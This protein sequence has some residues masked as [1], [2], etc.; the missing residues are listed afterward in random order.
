[1]ADGGLIAS[2][3]ASR[4]TA[5]ETNYKLAGNVWTEGK[6]EKKKEEE[7]ASFI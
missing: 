1:M 4:H 5:Y 6:K 3:G 2:D 7:E